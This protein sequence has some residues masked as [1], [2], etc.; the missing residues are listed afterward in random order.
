LTERFA[1]AVS[2]KI[3]RKLMDPSALAAA[4]GPRPRTQ[5]V[6]MCHG[7]FDIV[8]PGHIRHLIFAKQQ[9]DKLV[10][11]LTCDAHIQKGPHRPYIPEELRAMNLAALEMVDFVL[12]DRNAKPLENLKLIEPDV[13]VKGFEYT[14]HGL[15]PATREEKEVVESY[16][17]EIVFSPGDIVYSSSRI[18]DDGPPNLSIDKLMSLMSS[19]GIRFDDLISTVEK[20]PGR[21]VHVVGDTII[22]GITRTTTIGA[23]GKTPTLSVRYE[24]ETRYVGGAGVVAKHLAAAG[25]QVILT[26]VMGED[27]P[28][29]FALKDLAEAGVE[30]RP[31]FDGHRPTTFKNAFVADGVRL[32]KVDKLDN[33]PV[34]DEALDRIIKSTTEETAD[35]VVFSDF[36]HGIFHR[37]SI[38]QLRAA[39]PANAFS[40]ADSQVASRWGNILDFKGFDLITP[41]EREARFAM[42]DQDTVIRP[43]SNQLYHAAECKFMI[44]K[45]GSRG[46]IGCRP[47]PPDTPDFKSFFVIDSF[48][49]HTVDSVGAGDAMLAYATLSMLAAKNEVVAAILGT[50]AAAIECEREG[51]VPV[52]PAQIIGRIG[53]LSRISI[54]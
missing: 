6:I 5:K 34:V 29:E 28:S 13:F 47:Q 1:G 16:G 35:A 33:R 15:H 38:P 26:T 46:V 17:G 9:G 40:V 18:I 48:A 23:S 21:R 32:L 39:I 27:E 41:N 19:E 45:V 53:K 51:N 31:I 25:A 7:T 49:E 4:I 20:M 52:T 10:A 30:V 24:Q 42:A 11:S 14:S 22:D 44:L 3:S 37:L 8:H 2:E 50:L 36:R 43:L 12:I 54:C